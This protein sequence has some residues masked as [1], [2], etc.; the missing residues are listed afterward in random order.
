[1]VRK[2]SLLFL[3]WISAIFTF[4]QYTE[5]ISSDRPGQAYSATTVGGGIF[6]LQFGGGYS[7]PDDA[8]INSNEFLTPLTLRYG[9][10]EHLELSFDWTFQYVEYV[11]ALET[12]S[13][14]G[15]NSPS[16]SARLN[17]NDRQNGIVPVLTVQGGAQLKWDAL[18]FSSDEILPFGRLIAGYSI[19]DKFGINLNYGLRANPDSET[20]VHSYVTNFSYNFT[21][22]FGA[23]VEFYGDVFENLHIARFD[24]GLYLLVTDN[25]QLDLNAGG[26]TLNSVLNPFFINGGVS[27]RV[28]RKQ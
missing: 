12:F 17:I 21:D 25:L 15:L 16:L 18:E 24:Y 6:Q 7:T 13:R 27:W 23:I 11:T 19:G 22:N 2:I 8:T 1:M 5:Q 9:I 4:A 14:T 26:H 28:G 10:T 3:F 20:V